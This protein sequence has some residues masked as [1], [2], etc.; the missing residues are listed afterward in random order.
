MFEN[1]NKRK[2]DED[3]NE[4]SWKLHKNIGDKGT[5]TERNTAEASASGAITGSDIFCLI[6]IVKYMID[7][8]ETVISSTIVHADAENEIM[9]SASTTLQYF[10]RNYINHRN[11]D[12][13][14]RTLKR[15]RTYQV[16]YTFYDED[17]GKPDNFAN[18]YLRTCTIKGD[19]VTFT[20]SGVLLETIEAEGWTINYNRL[21]KL[22]GI[23]RNLYM[24][25]A[26]NSGNTFTQTK[27]EQRL[28]LTEESFKNRDAI[29]KALNRFIKPLGYIKGYKVIKKGVG[30]YSFELD[31]SI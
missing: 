31:R 15:L 4:L 14:I 16:E 11:M 17:T 8:C 7:N 1:T 28:G 29:K 23:Y 6:G 21:S 18:H 19:K 22:S 26:Q 24:Y 12:E 20:I 27:L 10:L 5:I 2:F 9:L 25:I 3:K 30:D 13:L